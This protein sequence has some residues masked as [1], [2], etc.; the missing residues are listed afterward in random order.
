MVRLFCGRVEIDDV[1]AG[2]SIGRGETIE[3]ETRC[4]G[5]I[6][7]RARPED[8]TAILDGF[9]S[10]A[11]VVGESP[12]RGAAEFFEDE[13]GFGGEE[14]SE[15]EMCCEASEDFEVGADSGGR[16]HGPAA[17]DDTTFEVSHGAFFFGP[18][19]GG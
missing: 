18:L 5:V 17:K 11:G 13:L 1:E 8:S 15:S 6:F 16:E 10:D 12:G 7:V 9:V 14:A 19:G 2:A 4:A 3:K